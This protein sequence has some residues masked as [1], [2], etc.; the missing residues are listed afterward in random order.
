[1]KKTLLFLIAFAPMLMQAQFDTLY[2]G[3][4]EPTFY[5][6][7]DEWLDYI[8][9][10]TD[11]DYHSSCFFQCPPNGAHS[12]AAEIARCCF[13]KDTLRV[14]G[15]AVA[16]RIYDPDIF[17]YTLG[18]AD[19]TL[20]PEYC[21][22]FKYHGPTDSLS[23]ILGEA[24]YDNFKPRYISYVGDFYGPGYCG[25][26][27][28]Y[29]DS[30]VYVS[31]TFYVSATENNRY[32]TGF[33]WAHPPTMVLGTLHETDDTAEY[34]IHPFGQI[35]TRVTVPCADFE[36]NKWYVWNLEGPGEF[37][38]HDHSYLYLHIFPIIDTSTYHDTTESSWCLAPNSLRA[39]APDA[40]STVLFWNSQS[41]S[42][43]D[44]SL[45]QGC[46]D[47]DSG[48]VMH[49]TTT[50]ANL[51]GLEPGATYTTWVRTICDNGDTSFW[52]ESLQFTVPMPADTGDTQRVMNV[53]DACFRLSPNP[54]SAM[55]N[56]F[57]SFQIQE[58]DI[59]SMSGALMKHEAP[60]ALSVNI[61]IS[62]LPQGLYV[63]RATTA[64][65][66]AYG[67]LVVR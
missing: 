8:W 22:I 59:F 49:Y 27:E 9:T 58:I 41:G 55:V 48:L 35:L 43:W 37:S 53:D 2:F 50:F 6:W 45:C 67:R 39:P 7:G 36:P 11:E 21:R 28:A 17:P 52:S 61:D 30:A 65:G 38:Y 60:K 33:G 57:S 10:H 26:Y 56:A 19:S 66:M 46:D 14:I 20:L 13:S 23:P 64:H 5:Y 25:I 4:R 12:N 47:P 18:A 34:N 63:V 29:F 62:D 40:E 16:S 32:T 31:D 44:V 42:E 24:R 3:D 51:T 54:A 15:V 1:M